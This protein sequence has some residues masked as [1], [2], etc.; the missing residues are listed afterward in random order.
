MEVGSFMEALKKKVEEANKPVE[1]DYRDEKG[2]LICGKCNTPREV[3]RKME[4]DSSTYTLFTE[5]KC[6]A[7]EAEERRRRFEESKEQRYRE[8]LEAENMKHVARLQDISLMGKKLLGANFETVTINQHNHNNYRLCRGYVNKWKEMEAKGQGLLFWGDVGTGKS[9]AAACI[10]NALLSNGV[11]VIMTSFIKLLDQMKDWDK[12][13]ASVI[14]KLNR[15][16]LLIIDELG[17]GRLTEYT[18]E[19]IFNIIDS[20]NQA[21]LPLIITTNLTLDE[22]YNHSNMARRRIYSRVLEKCFPMQFSGPSFRN[23]TAK[24]R[25]AE[26]LKLVEGEG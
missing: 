22:M 1:G 4:G 3:I 23:E 20:R 14:K 9:Y 7:A 17:A 15:A 12:E 21:D 10:A 19:K 13:D 26:M 25:Y 18:E 11:P 2:I 5:C 6:R 8:A 16:K 24:E